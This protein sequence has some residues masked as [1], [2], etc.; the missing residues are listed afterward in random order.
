MAV[1]TYVILPIKT[2]D[3]MEQQLHKE[4]NVAQ[5]DEQ[6][7]ARE[8]TEEGDTV[9]E[10]EKENRE[11]TSKETDDEEIDNDDHNQEMELSHKSQPASPK[12]ELSEEIKT[13]AKQK[14]LS[15]RHFEKLLQALKKYK[16]LELNFPDLELLIKS[17]VTQK[18][19]ILAKEEEFYQFL[20]DHGLLHFV[21]NKHKLSLYAKDWY[22]VVC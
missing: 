17:A 11:D 16:N 1:E 3:I 19:R 4:K 14:S 8:I 2:Y 10:K 18:R 7:D 9:G 15:A 22:R 5:P 6:P 20:K 12:A 13:Q 21:K